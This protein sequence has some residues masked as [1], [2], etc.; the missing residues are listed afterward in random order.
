MPVTEPETL[1]T[2]DVAR[3]G[4]GMWELGDLWVSLA[5]VQS[6]RIMPSVLTLVRERSLSFSPKTHIRLK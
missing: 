6:S 1:S 2:D 3:E 4:A 5:S